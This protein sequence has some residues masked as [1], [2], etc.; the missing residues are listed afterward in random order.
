VTLAKKPN[1]KW[2]F[3]IDFRQLNECSGN[4]GWPLPKIKEVLIRLG[5]TKAKYFGTIDLTA[6]YHQARLHPNSR[7]YTTFKTYAGSYQWTRVPFGLK[8]A[9]SY[10]Q[11]QMALALEDLVERI[12]ELYVDDFVIYGRTEEEFV[13]NLRT[14]LERLESLGITVNPA[15][16]KFGLRE[17]EYVGHVIN[18]HG[19]TMSDDKRRKVLDFPRPATQKQLRSYLGLVNYFR[20]HLRD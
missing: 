11:A 6:G 13:E 20:D 17:V 3:C 2:R 10:F 12:C 4:M 18:E 16:C 7:K 8:G 5:A 15:K 9:P 14:V 1:G 19:K